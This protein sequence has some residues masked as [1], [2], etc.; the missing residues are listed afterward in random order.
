MLV[1]AV[2]LSK[3]IAEGECIRI[4]TGAAVPLSA[5]AVVQVEDTELLKAT[6]DGKTELEINILKAPSCGQDIRY[7]I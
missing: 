2:Q 1:I 6:D 4:S 3:E 5:N 7:F